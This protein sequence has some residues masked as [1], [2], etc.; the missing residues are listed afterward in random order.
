MRILLFLLFFCGAIPVVHATALQK[1]VVQH[2]V[3]KK[4]KPTLKVDTNSKVELR[5]FDNEAIKNYSK[6]RDFI[7]DDSQ[8]APSLWDRFWRWI[9]SLI[10]EVLGN[11]IGGTIIKYVLVALVIALIVFIVLKLMGIDFK[12]LTGK[13]KTINVPYQ[14]GLENIHEIDFDEQIEQAMQLGN[15]RLVVRLLYLKTL[16]QLSDKELIH[17]LP[18]KTNQAYVLEIANQTQQQEFAQLTNQFEYIWYGEFFIDK[19]SFEPIQES[20]QQFNQQ[21]A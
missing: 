12:L 7:Y 8:Q 9:W 14:E 3:A 11:K 15:Y 18:E 4:E 17:W 5:K 19:S 1:P 10:N 16:K 6:K 2:A 13:S 20:F 21:K